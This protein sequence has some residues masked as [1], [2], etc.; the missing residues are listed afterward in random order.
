ML[1]E[2]VSM[3]VIT[4]A[5]GGCSTVLPFARLPRSCGRSSCLAA[6]AAYSTL[7]DCHF[8]ALKYLRAV[9]GFLESACSL[10]GELSGFFRQLR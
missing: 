8:Y 2:G 9:L 10:T 6:E 5:R 3:R 4:C 1:S 7:F